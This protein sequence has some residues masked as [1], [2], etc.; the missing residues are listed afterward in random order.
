[1]ECVEKKILRKKINCC[2]SWGRVKTIL[3]FYLDNKQYYYKHLILLVKYIMLSTDDK[4][5]FLVCLFFATDKS[6]IK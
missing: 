5:N 6:E 2:F 3:L 4:C 1:M